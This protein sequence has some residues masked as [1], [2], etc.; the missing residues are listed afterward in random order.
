MLRKFGSTGISI[1]VRAHNVG[2]SSSEMEKKK[3]REKE[4][5]ISTPLACKTLRVEGKGKE[6]VILDILDEEYDKET[7][8]TLEIT[9]NS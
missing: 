8:D 3:R 2:S 1:Q 9:R 6:Q 7:K 5:D 4:I